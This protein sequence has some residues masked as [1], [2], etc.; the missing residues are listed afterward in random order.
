MISKLTAISV[1]PLPWMEQSD[2]NH[3]EQEHRKELVT[4]EGKNMIKEKHSLSKE[5]IFYSVPESEVGRGFSDEEGVSKET[6]DSP[7][8]KTSNQCKRSDDEDAKYIV[9]NRKSNRITNPP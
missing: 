1:T 7:I 5:E 3:D 8:S 9:S 6:P 4:T 2:K